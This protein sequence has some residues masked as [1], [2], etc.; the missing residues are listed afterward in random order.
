MNV[1]RGEPRNLSL[2]Q[3]RQA[4]TRLDREIERGHFL[5]RGM[6]ERI[7]AGLK[8]YDKRK[9]RFVVAG[10]L[11]H[12]INVQMMSGQDCGELRHDSRAVP[13]QKT[14]VPR[15]L[16]VAAYFRRR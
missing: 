14:Q 2:T 12:R 10:F 5:Q 13:D 11:Q 4:E 7:P 15:S 9:S 16:E 6:Q 3:N 1:Q 8:R